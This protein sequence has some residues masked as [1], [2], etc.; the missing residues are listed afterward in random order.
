MFDHPENPRHPATWFTM[1]KPFA[2]LA[3]TLNLEA[4]PLT[5]SGAGPLHLRYAVAL[6]DGRRNA[7]QVDGLYRKWVGNWGAQGSPRVKES[8]QGPGSRED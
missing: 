6:W 2:Y 8:T 7:E 5:L 3:A 4:E 1:A